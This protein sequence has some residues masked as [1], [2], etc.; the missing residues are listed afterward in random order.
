MH[1]LARR[2]RHSAVR[3]TPQSDDIFDVGAFSSRN[4]EAKRQYLQ[5]DWQFT[6]PESAVLKPFREKMNALHQDE[7]LQDA[8]V[9][10]QIEDENE[11]VPHAPMFA[12]IYKFKPEYLDSDMDESIKAHQEYSQLFP[13]IISDEVLRVSGHRGAVSIWIGN[14]DEDESIIK[15]EI[16]K[17]IAADPFIKEEKV[18]E[19]DVL[20]ISTSTKEELSPEEQKQYDELLAERRQELMKLLQ[21]NEVTL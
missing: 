2:T 17:Y 21:D 11:E 3:Q 19:W 7:D 16:D 1:A 13:Y 20:D 18:E 8:E 9:I 10:D 15:Q 4:N 14:Q 6:A 12:V 5:E